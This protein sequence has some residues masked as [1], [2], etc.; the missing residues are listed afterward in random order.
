LIEEKRP[1]LGL[2]CLRVGSVE[3]HLNVIVPFTDERVDKILK[4]KKQL[5]P[6]ECNMI[7]LDI[8]M[9]PANLKIWSELIGAVLLI[10][11]SLTIKS[12]TVNASLV[13]HPNARNPLPMG[14]IQLTNDYFRRSLEYPYRVLKPI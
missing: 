10:Q 3:C 7:I 2:S 5:S 11:K 4:E 14:F 13:V 8:S 1:A 12:L 6:E 9:I